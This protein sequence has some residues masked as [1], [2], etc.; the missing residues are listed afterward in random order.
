MLPQ[1]LLLVLS[2][3]VSAQAARPACPDWLAPQTANSVEFLN[4]E[5]S[6]YLKIRNVVLGQILGNVAF[7]QIQIPQSLVKRELKFMTSSLN[8]MSQQNG[9]R[10]KPEQRAYLSALKAKVRFF[11]EASRIPYV[12]YVDLAAFVATGL[13]FF[14]GHELNDSWMRADTKEHIRRNLPKA[15]SGFHDF[16]YAVQASRYATLTDSLAQFTDFIPVPVTAEL[17]PGDLNE[18]WGHGIAPMGLLMVD[19]KRGAVDYD[20]NVGT[21]I[22]FLDHDGKHIWLRIQEYNPSAFAPWDSPKLWQAR[23]CGTKLYRKLMMSLEW[24]G[25][26][27]LIVRDLFYDF[28]HER[29]RRLYMTPDAMLEVPEFYRNNLSTLPYLGD[30]TF[31]KSPMFAQYHAHW[32]G[33]EDEAVLKLLPRLFKELKQLKPLCL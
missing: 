26:E 8:K 15:A 18:L 14:P 12:D 2:L 6:V 3:T 28:F 31:T 11:S 25:K 16:E 32:R 19:R 4:P 5:L 10:L 17:D 1:I 9:G 20:L 21:S 13:S 24:Q 33:V 27:S 30:Q 22:N 29:N 23:D 7:S